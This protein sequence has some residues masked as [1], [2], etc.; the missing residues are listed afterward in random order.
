MR[1]DGEDSRA[2]RPRARLERMIRRQFRR[3]RGARRRGVR[4][5]DFA[6]RARRHGGGDRR[7]LRLRG[8]E[9]ARR[10]GEMLLRGACSAAGFGNSGFGCG[11]QV[12]GSGGGA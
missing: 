1:S 6:D 9:F 8:V 11:A 7:R 10:G 5:Q 12:C 4:L 2:G 3:D